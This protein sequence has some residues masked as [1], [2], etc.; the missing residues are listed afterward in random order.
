[1]LSA[2]FSVDVSAAPFVEVSSENLCLGFC[3]REEK[4][5]CKGLKL[6][7][8]SGVPRVFS[9]SFSFLR[10]PTRRFLFRQQYVR[11]V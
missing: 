1:M 2:L 10:P 8:P 4:E 11:F 6:I 9:T 3:C 7:V 5:F